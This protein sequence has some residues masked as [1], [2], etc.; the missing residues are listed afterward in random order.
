VNLSAASTTENPKADN[1]RMAGYITDTTYADTFFRELS[2]AWLNYV[3][4]LHGVAPR[5]L[6]RPF[7][8]L[9]LGCGFGTSSVVNAATFPHGSF[10][11]CDLNDAHIDR[12]RAYAARLGLDNIQLHA[13]TFAALLDAPLPQFDFIALHGVYSW[14]DAP[15]REVIRRLIA[16]L[17]LPGGL[18]YVS[19]NALPGWAHEL[20]LRKLL[21]EFAAAFEGTAADR[22]AAAA[23]QVN[24]LS[25]A[26]LRY[27]TANP[28]T[29]S[30]VDAYTRGE[31]HYLAHEFMNAAWEPFYGVDVADEFAQIGLKPA[32][33]A[34][35]ADNHLPLIV[36]AKAAEAISSLPTPRQQQLAIDF[37]T[38]QRFR[39]DVFV[40]EDGSLPDT[41]H[42]DSVVIG[43]AWAPGEIGVT[44]RVPRG[45]MRFQES[46]IRDVRALMT[47]GS[48]TFRDAVAN[49]GGGHDTAGVERNLLFLTAGGSLAP[50]ASEH[51]ITTAAPSKIA[52]AI[53]EKALTEA[54][55][56]HRTRSVIPSSVYGNGVEMDAA[57]ARR[58][59]DWSQR[60]DRPV[61][62]VEPRLEMYTRLGFIA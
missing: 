9:E 23:L 39:R 4:A 8:Y 48:C 27:F 61:P 6:D 62:E 37:A 7:S 50:F 26:A 16:R 56:S 30:A 28:G 1:Q 18:V 59:L 46:F 5:P 15:T 60:P 11:A 45:E 20:P 52:T 2:P 58:L 29:K 22:S 54:A 19:Y 3:A 42:L 13:R 36:D 24:T 38:N 17:L 55:G 12:A 43:C 10:H 25:G 14:V 34:T 32:G 53:V 49:L 57:E 44:V 51:R 35:L 41:R 21:V 47:R 40:R 31:G 33:S